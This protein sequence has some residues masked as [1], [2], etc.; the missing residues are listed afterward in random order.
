M[1]QEAIAELQKAEAL[2]ASHFT[3]GVLA[4]AYGQAGQQKEALQLIKE[5]ERG[6]KNESI[7]LLPL[8]WAYAGLGDKEK[9]FAWL[10]RAYAERRGAL[11]Y[12]NVEPLFE[13]LR[14]DARFQDLVRRIGLPQPDTAAVERKGNRGG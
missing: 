8:V 5:L 6:A 14:S 9:A 13:P 2:K 3:L 1:Y 7:R 12:L 10:E 11:I 4:H